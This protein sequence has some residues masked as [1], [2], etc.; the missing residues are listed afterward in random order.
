MLDVV[1][2]CIEV[3]RQSPVPRKH[4]GRVGRA[5]KASDTGREN[6]YRCIKSGQDIYIRKNDFFLV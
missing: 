4:T 6:M 3:L 5:S 2:R 1:S